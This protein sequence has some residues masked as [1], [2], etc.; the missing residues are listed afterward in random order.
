MFV[1]IHPSVFSSGDSF[2]F[3]FPFC[4]RLCWVFIAAQGLPVVVETGGSSV[5]A[6]HGILIAAESSSSRCADAPVL[7]CS[8]AAVVVALRAVVAVPGLSCSSR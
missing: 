2:F 7:P 3:F 6:V 4:S 1:R 8:A 5:V